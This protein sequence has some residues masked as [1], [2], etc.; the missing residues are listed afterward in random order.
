LSNA[1]DY[2]QGLKNSLRSDVAKFQSVTVW[3]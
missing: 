2:A 3:K 1:G